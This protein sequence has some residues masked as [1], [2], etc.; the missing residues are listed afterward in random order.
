M[1]PDHEN[2]LVVGTVEDRDLTVGGRVRVNP[3]QVVVGEFLARWL[4]EG[5]DLHTLRIRAI[6]YMAN[7]SVLTSGVDRLEH[8]QQSV[9]SFCVEELLQFL[10]ASVE[11]LRL[12]MSF[13]LAA[14]EG[15]VIAGVDLCEVDFGSR[16]DTIPPHETPSSGTNL[17]HQPRPG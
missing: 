1:D 8:D 9:G 6:E 16:F 7:R 15:R 10:E 17:L 12:T 14:F 3:P 4:F 2:V 11:P 5:G 13:L